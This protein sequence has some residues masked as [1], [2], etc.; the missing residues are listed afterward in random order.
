[1]ALARFRLVRSK[2]ENL[3]VVGIAG[4]GDALA[5]WE[6]TKKSVE[7]IQEEKPDTVF[8]LSTNGLLL[9]DLAADIVTLGIRHVTVTVNCTDPAVGPGYTKKLHTGGRSFQVRKAPGCF[10]ETSWPASKPSR[11]KMSW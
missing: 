1:M 2:L 6:K 5:D 9:P 7:L 11:N 4:P 8:C 10:S 3:S